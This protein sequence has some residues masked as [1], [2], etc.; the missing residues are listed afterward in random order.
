M[1]N[2]DNFALLD[3][4]LEYSD[5][6]SCIEIYQVKHEVLSKGK[7]G[8]FFAKLLFPQ[9]KIRKLCLRMLDRHEYFSR[10]NIEYCT[11]PIQHIYEKFWRELYNNPYSY[12][13]LRIELKNTFDDM[14]KKKGEG[15]VCMCVQ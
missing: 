6:M 7:I 1:K 10:N 5:A 9:R 12:N 2:K 11:S 14:S 13:D 4:H 8:S 3:I 15:G